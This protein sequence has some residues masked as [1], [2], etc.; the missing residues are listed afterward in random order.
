MYHNSHAFKVY[1]L[2]GFIIYIEL[3][4]ITTVSPKIDYSLQKET[5]F[6]LSSQSPFLGKDKHIHVHTHPQTKHSNSW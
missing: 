4:T 3:A 6:S 2:L 1:S 5:P